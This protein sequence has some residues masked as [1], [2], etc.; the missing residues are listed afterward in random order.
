MARSEKAGILINGPLPHWPNGRRGSVET[1]LYPTDSFGNRQ[2]CGGDC[3]SLL[4]SLSIAARKVVTTSGMLGNRSA[5]WCSMAAN[6]RFLNA[7]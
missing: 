3:W 1:S 7:A 4:H 2:Y 6:A 5:S